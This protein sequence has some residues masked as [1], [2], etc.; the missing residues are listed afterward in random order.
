M[1]GALIYGIF[2]SGERQPW[3]EDTPCNNLTLKDKPMEGDVHRGH[4]NEA[5]ELG[6]D[7]WMVDLSPS[8]CGYI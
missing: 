2:A 5:L 4:T 1:A 6:H 3:A 8:T 7:D